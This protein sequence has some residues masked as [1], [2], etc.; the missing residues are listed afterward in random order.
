MT[1]NP[2][3]NHT[4][5]DLPGVLNCRNVGSIH[6]LSQQGADLCSVPMQRMVTP[7]NKVKAVEKMSEGVPT[8][9]QWLTNP[10]RNHEVLGSIP[11]LAQWVKDPA[12]P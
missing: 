1:E 10:T 4:W 3:S 5:M 8:M 12:L 6:E 2:A 7:G 11:G 9:A